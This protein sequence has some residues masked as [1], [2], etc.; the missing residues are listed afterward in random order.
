ALLAATGPP[1]VYVWV[2]V[3]S[4][5][6]RVQDLLARGRLSQAQ[7]DLTALC[8]LGVDRHRS[9]RE[10][11]RRA[12]RAAEA[13][14]RMPLEPL[15]RGQALA[16]L[17]RLDEAAAALAGCPESDVSATLLLAT[18]LQD[19]QAWAESD[20]HYRRALAL[21][22]PMNATAAVTAARQRT[23]SGLAFNARASHN[24]ADAE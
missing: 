22:G 15:Q 4:E 16:V 3:R 20:R 2:Q 10:D 13:M 11:V 24:P 8:D 23:Y 17:G 7:S 5:T 18:I 6:S 9:T 1:A 14:L 21:L 19:R 12:L